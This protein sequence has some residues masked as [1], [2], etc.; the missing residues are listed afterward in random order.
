MAKVTIKDVAKEAGVSIGTV[1]N[2]LN[3]NRYIHPDTKQKVMDAVEKLQYVPNLNGRYLKAG[4]TK[5]LGFFTNSITGPYFA[6]IIDFMCRQCEKKGYNMTVFVTKD[7]SVIMGNIMGKRLDGVL[8]YEDTTVKE[9][10]ISMFEKEG[11]KAVFLDREI[12]RRG[13]ASIL[14]DSYH[15]GYEATKY[16]IN[17]GH[18]R[19]GFIESGDEVFDSYHRKRG[20]LAALREYH[21]PNDES[22]ILQG[23]FEEEYTYNSIIS[24]L[25]ANSRNMPDAILAG[26]DLSAIGCI[27]ALKANGY[28][29]P[30][31]VS[32][33][34]LT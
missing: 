1:S 20:Y 12:S 21:L 25:R 7:S 32:V 16:L 11:V 13:V 22:L 31:D 9:N 26:N 24:F 3:G 34:I 15:S 30:E 4:S 29:V 23:A 5:T 27:K 8:I 33:M 10:E 2:A 6:S 17:L 14:F 19:I 18:K 28:Q